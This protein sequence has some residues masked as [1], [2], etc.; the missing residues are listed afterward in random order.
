MEE[1][2]EKRYG[3]GYLEER[4]LIPRWR[5]PWPQIVNIILILAVFY[6]SWWIFQDRRGWLR[7][8]TPILVTCIP[9]G[10]SSFLFGWYISL[11]S[12]LSEEGS[13]KHGTLYGKDL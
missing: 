11:N 2:T 3:E 13:L 1:K 4:I 9:G 8:Y 7:M 12:G 10:Y 5:A 6:I